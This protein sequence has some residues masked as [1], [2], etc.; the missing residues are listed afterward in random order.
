MG[1]THDFVT[2]F[3]DTQT[4]TL[5]DTVYLQHSVYVMYKMCVTGYKMNSDGKKKKNK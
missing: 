5:T 4:Y 1:T 2:D 3:R